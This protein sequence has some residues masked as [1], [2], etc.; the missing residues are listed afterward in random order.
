MRPIATWATRPW[1]SIHNIMAFGAKA[2][3]TYYQDGVRVL[4]VSN[5]LAPVEIGYYN[6]W[7]PQA[8]YTSSAFYE[9]A[10]GLDVDRERRMIFVADSPRGLLILADNTP[11][12]R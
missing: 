1:I 9:G 10:V 12:P 3:M 8:D 2:Y 5:P 4:D 7:D 11:D 6:T